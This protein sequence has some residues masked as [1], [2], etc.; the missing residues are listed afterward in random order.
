MNGLRR[1]SFGSE[2]FRSLRW[3]G[4]D[5]A[6]ASPSGRSVVLYHATAYEYPLC[7]FALPDVP[8]RS[9][10][11]IADDTDVLVVDLPVGAT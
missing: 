11:A 2:P 1:L 7:V 10:F 6:V 4:D 5:R 3:R 8:I 9:R